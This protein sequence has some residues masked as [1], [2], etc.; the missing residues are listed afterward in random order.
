[1]ALKKKKEQT[2]AYR[3]FATREYGEGEDTKT[4]WL[5]V[6]TAFVHEKS[7]QVLLDAVPLNG[8]LV[9]LLEEAQEEEE[10]ELQIPKRR[11]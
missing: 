11:R 10:E 8:K 7:I 4:F 5:R 3:V 9:I 6:G 1:M 2:P